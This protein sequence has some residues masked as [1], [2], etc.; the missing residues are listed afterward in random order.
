MTKNTT[1]IIRFVLQI[2]QVYFSDFIKPISADML[3]CTGTVVLRKTAAIVKFA[4][5]MDIIN[6]LPLL[7]MKHNPDK[8]Q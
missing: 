5:T 2:C 3:R 6:S 4:T 1:Y 7:Q 8:K